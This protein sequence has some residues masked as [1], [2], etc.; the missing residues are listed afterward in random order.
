MQIHFIK[1]WIIVT[2]SIPKPA[3]SDNVMLNLY[4]LGYDVAYFFNIYT[5]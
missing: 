3:I 2:G 1:A 4:L 5:S